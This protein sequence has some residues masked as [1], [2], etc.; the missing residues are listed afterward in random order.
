VVEEAG[1]PGENHRPWASN[2]STL[3]LEARRKIKRLCLF[4]KAFHHQ[5]A[6]NIPDLPS[7]YIHIDMYNNKTGQLAL[8]NIIHRN[9]EMYKHQVTLI[10]TASFLRQSRTGIA[11]C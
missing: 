10:N 3:S 4:H 1:V 5:I 9:T 11:C 8:G 2:W 6:I 7:D